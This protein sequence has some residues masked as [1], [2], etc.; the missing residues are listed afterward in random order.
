MNAKKVMSAA[1][2]V[3][4]FVAGILFVT[5]GANVF[6]SE[7]AVLPTSWADGTTAIAA[8]D[9]NAQTMAF[10]ETFTQ[11]SESVNPAVVQIQ[12]S[13]TQ[14]RT[15]QSPFEGT[16]FEDFFQRRGPDSFESPTALGSGVIAR[17]NGYIITNNH[18]V[19]DATEL[20][21]ILYDGTSKDAEVVGRD[22]ASDLAVIK[23]DGE[24]LPSISFGDSDEVKAGQWVL[25][26]GSP[27]QEYLS[28]SVTAGIVSAVG[29][30][31]PGQGLGVRNF[32]QTDAAI[33]PGNSGGPLVDIQGRL[34]GINTAIV[35][36]SGGYQGIGFAIPANTVQNVTEQLIETGTVTRA[37]MGVSYGPAPETLI[38]NENL[39]PGSAVVGRVE[40]DSPAD[41][42]GL[43]A[44]D[45]IVALDGEE[46]QRYLELGNFVTERRPGEEVTVTVNRNGDRQDLT[47]ELGERES[48][49]E[50]A[51]NGQES[52]DQ[53][54]SQNMMEDLGFTYR[55]L[56]P[57]IAERL[58]L[59]STDGVLVTDVDP[60]NR[61]I[62]DSG[63]REGMVI[64]RMNGE[65]TPDT[66][67]FEAAYA[68]IEAGSA[69]R[70]VV[71]GQQG[72][73]FVTSLRKP[74]S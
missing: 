62:R 48:N 16:P 15:M 31:R 30:L 44:G 47:V 37:Y 28:N 58:G 3:A 74:E 60:R 43:Q 7:R 12:A 19:E 49:G 35:T 6:G 33:N 59:D 73:V 34:V 61:M 18:V 42:A 72:G 5:I 54:S 41:D 45:I 17:S 14:R 53:P 13:R 8:Q 24:S 65:P 4:A 40:T 57:T 39:P 1:V 46:L 70:V 66:D 55:G 21:V 69:F 36:R 63:L 11:V 27:L 25:A 56:T 68:D 50:T 51:D 23:V 38:E 67:A 2:I 64:I 52:P 29:R 9:V 26:F 32:I 20:S 71:R 10:Q 22:E